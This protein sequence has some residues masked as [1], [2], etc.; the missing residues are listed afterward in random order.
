MSEKCGSKFFETG[1]EKQNLDGQNG[2]YAPGK[3]ELL[4]KKLNPILISFSTYPLYILILI[5]ASESELLSN[6]VPIPLILGLFA[7]FELFDLLLLNPPRRYKNGL[8]LETIVLPEEDDFNEF[9]GKI[10]RIEIF[11]CFTLLFSIWAFNVSCSKILREILS[12]SNYNLYSLIGIIISLLVLFTVFKE[13]G[14]HRWMNKYSNSTIWISI[15]LQIASTF[16]LVIGAFIRSED[17]KT[18]GRMFFIGALIML[19]N[20]MHMR[21]AY[22]YK[23]PL[24]GENL[25]TIKST[26]LFMKKWFL[27]FVL[28]DW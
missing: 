26:R 10:R 16:T 12:P 8:Q 18:S 11:H 24:R 7:T 4:L 14:S 6:I 17:P 9:K 13:V 3:I 20:A 23:N 5:I 28:M 22:L 2:D 25:L 27:W 21:F 1:D 15:I 19:A